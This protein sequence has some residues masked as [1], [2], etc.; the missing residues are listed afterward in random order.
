[1]FICSMLG[2]YILQVLLFHEW[3]KSFTQ[4]SI[5]PNS[6]GRIMH[7]SLVC[8]ILNNI[9]TTLSN[10]LYCEIPYLGSNTWL[11]CC[12]PN[13]II[14]WTHFFQVTGFWFV[15]FICHYEC[16]KLKPVTC[17]KWDMPLGWWCIYPKQY[18]LYFMCLKRI[19]TTPKHLHYSPELMPG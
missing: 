8:L 10:L 14:A 11:L 17:E 6:C 18:I 12:Q 19:N 15:P 7:I 4:G 16:Y 13:K 1:M 9:G 5:S 2:R 3:P